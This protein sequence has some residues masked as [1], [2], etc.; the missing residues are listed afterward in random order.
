MAGALY[1]QEPAK[2]PSGTLTVE[3]VIT[4]TKSGVAEDL[5][6]TAIKRRGKPF[7]LNAAE[8]IELKNLGV[9]QTVIGYLLDPSKPY[10][11]PPPPAAG[12]A[13]SPPAVAGPAAPAEP[14]DPLAAKTPHEP[15]LYC[16]GSGQS[17]SPLNLRPVVPAKQAGKNSKLFGLLK[18]H[19]I[20][21]IIEPKADARIH[22]GE[23]TIFALRLPEK[24][25]ID[26]YALLRLEVA[27]GRRN[28]D[29]GKTPGKPVFRFD[30]RA[31]FQSRR[32]AP[33]IYRISVR[34]T[35]KGEYLFLILGSSDDAKGLLGKGYDF[36]VD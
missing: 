32:L 5:I 17:F 6:V 18:G 30:A 35:E 28:L 8:I 15:G 34:L 36:G 13:H 21:S 2:P 26:D 10:N 24:A 31:A 1:S 4:M 33:G 7:D 14:L 11:P 22:A 19:I 9:S 12:D 16:V 29:F 25:S 20:G 23:E 27:E 3:E